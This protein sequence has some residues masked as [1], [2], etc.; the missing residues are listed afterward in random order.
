M[1]K[2]LVATGGGDCPGLNAVIRG[3]SRAAK[4]IGDIEVWGSM[5]A[6]NGI[7]CDPVDLVR[8]NKRRTAGIHVKG[9]TII[10]TTNK[11]NPLSYPTLQPDG[12][13]VNVDR[14]DELIDKIRN[15]GFDAVINICLLYTSPSPRD[16]QKSRMPSSA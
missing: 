1:K 13:F 15:N 12:T 5:E 2:I 8:L 11:G 7:L 16:R 3:I 9:G 14:S 6:F 4:H 10:R